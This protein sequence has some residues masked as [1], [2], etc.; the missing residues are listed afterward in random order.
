MTCTTRILISA[1]SLSLVLAACGKKPEDAAV[2]AAIKASTGQDATV[3]H[4]G[5]GTTMTVNTGQGQMKIQSGNGL[6]LPADFPG[7]VYLPAGYQIENVMQMGPVNSVVLSVSGQA[8]GL[9]QEIAAKMQA[10][11]WKTA[12]SMQSANQGAMLS[13]TRDKRSVTYSMSP[14]Q[15]TGKVSLS[16]QH[17]EEQN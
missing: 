11:G 5:D 1:I 14:A 16:V 7:D 10:G 2:E 4:T 6:T 15:E 3:E 12:L 17:T 8:Q 13:F 9:A